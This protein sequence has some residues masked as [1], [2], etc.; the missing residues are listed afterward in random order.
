MGNNP[1][2]G[3]SIPEQFA[4]II[5]NNLLVL[6][7]TINLLWGRAAQ[8][9]NVPQHCVQA[10]P[11][12]APDIDFKN[13]KA[14][15]V[16]GGGP[17]AAGATK[18]RQLMNRHFRIEWRCHDGPAVPGLV[19]DFTNSEALYLNTLVKIR[20]ALDLDGSGMFSAIRISSEDWI[21]QQEGSDGLERAGNVIRF[22]TTVDIPVN[23]PVPTLVALTSPSG[24]VTTVTM[25]QDTGESVVIDQG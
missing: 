11:L 9:Q 3:T 7:S 19:P 21:D 5:F 6:D 25:G 20:E 23:E 8:E 4:N 10:I 1:I 15:G 22:F 13:M 14:G 17:I 18:G 12:G 24:I 16:F 2:T